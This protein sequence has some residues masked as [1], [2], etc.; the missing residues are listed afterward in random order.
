LRIS[1]AIEV[2]TRPAAA[3]FS[4]ATSAVNAWSFSCWVVDSIWRKRKMFAAI[5]AEAFAKR[6]AVGI[7]A[8]AQT[9]L[10]AAESG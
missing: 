4:E 3:S 1:W 7:D 6:I 2:A 10:T 9:T 5:A 8:A